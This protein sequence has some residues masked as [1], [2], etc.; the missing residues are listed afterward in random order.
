[1]ATF[2]PFMQGS[3]AQSVINDYLGGKLE[4]K[5]N[6]NKAGKF[7]NPLYDLRT[8]QEGLGELDPS[9]DFPNPQLD[10]SATDAPVDPCKEGFM[11][12]DGICQPIEK[13]GQSQYDKQRDDNNVEERPYM[14]IEEMTNASDYEL[15]KYLDDGWLKGDKFNATIGGTLMPPAFM[16][17]FGGQNKMRRDF[18]ID[19]LTRRG[20]ATGVNDKGQ[21]TF[22]LGNVFGIISNADAA[23]KGINEN[24]LG[25][26]TPEEINYQIEAKNQADAFSGNPYTETMTY[27]QIIDDAN[28]SGGTVNPHEVNF[29]PSPSNQSIFSFNPVTNPADDYDDESS[30]I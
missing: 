20:Y 14:S 18:I 22:N 10:F 5:P 16:L 15:L 2:T 25:F 7:R 24:Q 4:T 30:G 6:V 28:K 21:N 26:F 8:V 1:M 17:P 9:A 19:E 23:N 3:E 27:D 11:L 12:V 29:T 13:F